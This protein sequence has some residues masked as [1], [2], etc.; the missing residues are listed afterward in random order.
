MFTLVAASGILF[1]APEASTKSTDVRQELVRK[2]YKARCKPPEASWKNKCL[3]PPERVTTAR[4]VVLFI[5]DCGSARGVAVGVAA[6]IV[7]VMLD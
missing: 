3:S 5:P 6:R 4:D 2:E 1:L 7:V